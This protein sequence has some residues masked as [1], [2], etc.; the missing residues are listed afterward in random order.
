MIKIIKSRYKVPDILEVEGR[1]ATISNNRLY[2]SGVRSFQID[3]KIYGHSTV[4]EKLIKIQNGKCCFCERKIL[5]GDPGHIEHYRPKN[6]YKQDDISKLRKP[7]YYWL[8]YDFNNLYL[9][10]Y[11]CNSTYKRNFFPLLNEANRA[12]CH[13]NRI[14]N[15]IPLIINPSSD[16]SV[17]LIFKSE[18]IKPIKNSLYGKET[19]KRTGLNRKALADERLEELITLR[20]LAKLARSGDADSI[21]IFKRKGNKKSQF[22]FMVRC[23]FPDLV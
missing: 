10:C 3:K 6:G 8:A 21:A 22:S 19:I 18:I 16:P 13:R 15:E 11:R 2:N 4:K 14:S 12:L 1:S 17:H 23:N 5:A 7:G 20:A 9:S